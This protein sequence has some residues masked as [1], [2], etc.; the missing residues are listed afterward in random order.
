V[1]LASPT[2]Y[3]ATLRDGETGLLFR[4]SGTFE[5]QLAALLDQPA[6]RERLALAAHEYAR[7]HQMLADHIG[8][9]AEWYRWLAENRA[10]LT[11][12]LAARTTELF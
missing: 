4:D 8:R 10:E 5:R 3:E 11:A 6:L 1:A 2:V 7:R 12:K 9:Q